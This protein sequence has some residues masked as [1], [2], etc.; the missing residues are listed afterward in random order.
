MR[1]FL[2]IVIGIV[3]TIG[4]AY[5]YDSIRN[6]SGDQETFDRPVVNWDVLGHGVKSAA[7]AVQD[8]VSR[9]TGKS[10]ENP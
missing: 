8:G 10:K 5:I 4:A 9:L 6:T 3:L 1:M 2:G 7:S